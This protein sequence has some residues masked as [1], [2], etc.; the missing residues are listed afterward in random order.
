MLECALCKRQHTEKD[1]KLLT[2]WRKGDCNEWGKVPK[3]HSGKCFSLAFHGKLFRMHIAPFGEQETETFGLLI[4][5]KSWIY[6]PSKSI[7][8]RSEGFSNKLPN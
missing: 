2:T 7:G 3:L 8:N 4:I 5:R 6:L 1:T